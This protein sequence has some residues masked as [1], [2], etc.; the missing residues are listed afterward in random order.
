[1]I[2]VT[3]PMIETCPEGHSGRLQAPAWCDLLTRA[4]LNWDRFTPL[5]SGMRRERNSI[6]TGSTERSGSPIFSLQA[7][8]GSVR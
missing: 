2:T 1:M 8:V 4:F 7:A 3:I 6:P 5:C